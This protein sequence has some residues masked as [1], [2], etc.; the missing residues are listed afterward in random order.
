M[1]IWIFIG[2]VG[3]ILLFAAVIDIRLRKRKSFY[4]NKEGTNISEK[5]KNIYHSG[6][7]KHFNGGE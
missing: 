7:H 6:D 3:C 2:I 5:D 4:N 1:I